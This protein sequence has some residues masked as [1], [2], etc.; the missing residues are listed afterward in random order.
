MANAPGRLVADIGP[1]AHKCLKAVA[2][3]NGM[4]I[5]EY[6]WEKLELSKLL[7]Q[8]NK[9]PYPPGKRPTRQLMKAMKEAEDMTKG[10]RYKNMEE[11]RAAWQKEG[12][13]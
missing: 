1:E 12:F 6:V 10:T 8:K 7:K 2:A 9:S 11:L 13:L 5:T 4:S 3:L